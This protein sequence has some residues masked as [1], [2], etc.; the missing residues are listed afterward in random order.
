MSHSIVIQYPYETI[1]IALCNNGIITTSKSIHKNLAIGQTIPI[2]QELL[3]QNGLQLT[4]L[5]YFGANVGP[6]P[7]NTLRGILTMLNGIHQVLDT[8]MIANNALNLMNLEYAGTQHIVLLKAFENHLFFSLWT[9]EK[10]IVA[11]AE[12]HTIIDLIKQQET[13]L[14]AIGNG[15]LHYEKTLL[16][17][18]GD[19]IVIPKEL[20]L[21]NQL[22][23]LAHKSY[24][25][26]CSKT[27]L[28]KGTQNTLKPLYYED[29]DIT[30]E[31]KF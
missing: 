24:Q 30:L 3:A 6:G 18:C 31:K 10:K 5:S 26:F 25:D 23:T 19:K 15:A 2:I 4:D 12:L 11:S 7:Y 21:F 1:E 27:E 17:Q 8:A 13:A 16:E 28:K 20:P 29:L 9:S 22:D 14:V